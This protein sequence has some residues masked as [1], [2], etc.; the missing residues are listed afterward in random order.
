MEGVG[1]RSNSI[2]AIREQGKEHTVKR[3]F[4]VGLCMVAAYL[5]GVAT[6]PL[7]MH[8]SARSTSAAGSEVRWTPERGWETRELATN[9]RF[10]PPAGAKLDGIVG[11]VP[12]PEETAE[13]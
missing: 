6:L 5:A 13:P 12:T 10:D 9:P 8:L 2:P 4:I 7:M 1:Q 11:S 3:A